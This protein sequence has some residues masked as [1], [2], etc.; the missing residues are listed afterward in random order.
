MYKS[1]RDFASVQV[2][3]ELSIDDVDKVAILKLAT[4][5]SK[6]FKKNEI[7]F[8][9]TIKR[10]FK[11][12]EKNNVHNLV[13]DLRWNNGGTM[14]LAEYLF[15]FFIDSTY[16]YYADAEIKQPVME[17]ITKYAHSRNMKPVLEQQVGTLTPQDGVYYLPGEK[18][19]VEPA[20]P[21]FKGELYLLTNGFSFS[22]T[23]SFLAHIQQNDLGLVVGET[24][25]GAFAGVNAGPSLV[26]ELPNSKIR[27][28]YRIIGTTYNVDV[29][30][31]S[32]EV[33]YKIDNTVE[34]FYQGD[35]PQLEYALKLI[36]K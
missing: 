31:I 19:M 26:A 10:V 25:G 2:P 24:P 17:G 7:N 8:Q 23:S 29:N 3:L 22:A 13:I 20:K 21:Q 9:D 16:L 32:I 18:F 35:D 30:K 15:S 6:S 1:A 36:K 5:N 34:G 11:Y 12:L 14:S 4:F 27:L 33:D 28:Y